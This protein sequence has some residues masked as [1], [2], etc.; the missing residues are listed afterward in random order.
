MGERLTV[1]DVEVSNNTK[2]NNSKTK[3]WKNYEQ[4]CVNALVCECVNVRMR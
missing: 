4:E 3:N 2:S 1:N